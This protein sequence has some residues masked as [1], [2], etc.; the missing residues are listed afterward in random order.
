MTKWIV[1]LALGLTLS[2]PDA[3][4][5]RLGNVEQGY[6]FEVPE[7]WSLAHPDF[8]MI[9][10]SGASLSESFIPPQDAPS[11]Q[12][13]SKTAG[14]IALIGADYQETREQFDLQG[15]DWN[16]MVTVFIEPRRTQ[17]PQRHV[18]QMV[19]EHRGRFRLF[20]LAVPSQE[21]LQSRESVRQL[22]LALKFE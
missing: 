3:Q 6:W 21:W 14:M 12:Q 4:A 10:T 9:S 20:Y 15:D 16:A 2:T 8:T 11:L 19:T 5:R 22:L 7:Q 17:K 13:I 18:L 1:A